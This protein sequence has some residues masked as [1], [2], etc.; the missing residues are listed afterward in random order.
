MSN[1]NLNQTV[2][3]L[4]GQWQAELTAKLTALIEKQLPGSIGVDLNTKE[5]QK[6]LEDAKIK[7]A[8]EVLLGMT[9]EGSDFYYNRPNDYGRVSLSLS[10]GKGDPMENCCGDKMLGEYGD[11][12]RPS[13]L[14]RI[15]PKVAKMT[16]DQSY[17]MTARQQELQMKLKAAEKKKANA[18]KKAEKSSSGRKA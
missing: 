10:T 12:V 13:G 5:I 16:L 11:G 18:E 9:A 8:Q 4:A 15:D 17:R 14:Y 1:K 3:Q 2:Q 7:A 6:A